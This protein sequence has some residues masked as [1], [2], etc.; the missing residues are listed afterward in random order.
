MTW[1]QSYQQFLG[2]ILMEVSEFSEKNFRFFQ[3]YFLPKNCRILYK[4]VEPSTQKNV[5]D[6]FFE[7][8]RQI[9]VQHFLNFSGKISELIFLVGRIEPRSLW[10]QKTQRTLSRF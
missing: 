5:R 6:T 10:F 2:G 1:A 7:F 4:S 8:S 3:L 9:G